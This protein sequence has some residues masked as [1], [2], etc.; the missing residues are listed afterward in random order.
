[1]SALEQTAPRARP[2][3]LPPASA[4]ERAAWQERREA[5]Q[6]AFVHPPWRQRLHDF[7]RRSIIVA[8]GLLRW[9]PIVKRGEKNALAVGVRE[10]TAAF[11]D[12]PPAFDGYRILF[13]TDPHLDVHAGLAATA[14]DVVAGVEAE[15][16]AFGGDIY[17]RHTPPTGPMIERLERLIASFRC[18]EGVVG[19]L[20]NHDGWRL[21]ERMERLGVRMLI[22]ETITLRR[23]SDALHLTGVDDVH[24]FESDAAYAA[25]AAAPDGFAVALVHSPELARAAAARHRLYLCG[26]T[27]GGQI[28]LPGGRPIVT[29]LRH[30]RH[31][32]RGRWRIGDM[33]GY[34]S[35]GVGASMIPM[36]F[37]CRGE[38]TRITLKR[39]PAALTVS[40]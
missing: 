6:R 17:G 24:Y 4:P 10:L 12:L 28:C 16:G 19:V 3:P 34:T 2:A 36:R 7:A 9:T 37:N 14:A 27:H 20:G 25:L 32:A 30:D 11:P 1:M 21:V 5:L 26:H 38:V 29:S 33:L 23:G 40:G 18:S 22:N 35:C 15:L 39:G 31:L 8:H 13:V